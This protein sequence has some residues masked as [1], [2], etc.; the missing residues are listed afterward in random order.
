MQQEGNQKYL[1]QIIAQN[2]SEFQQIHDNMNDMN[3]QILGMNDK[4]DKNKDETLEEMNKRLKEANEKLQKEIKE[5]E[6]RAEYE[7][8]DALMRGKKSFV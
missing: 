7:V 8:R 1:E 2:Q 4:I 6:E 3:S 5:S